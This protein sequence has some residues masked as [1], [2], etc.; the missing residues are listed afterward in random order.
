MAKESKDKSRE[1]K[2]LREDKTEREKALADEVFVL[3]K[4]KD[5]KMDG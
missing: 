1:V 3:G 5:Y 4:E 2:D